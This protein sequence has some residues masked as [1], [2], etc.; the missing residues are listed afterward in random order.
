MKMKVNNGN[1][2]M[3]IEGTWEE[4]KYWLNSQIG[5]HSTLKNLFDLMDGKQ[6][7]LATEPQYK[8]IGE[9][10]GKKLAKVG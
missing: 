10:I 4:I 9:R 5:Q 1:W 6:M 3:E 2:V 7:E 8:N